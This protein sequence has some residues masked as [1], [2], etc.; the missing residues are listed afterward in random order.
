MQAYT[1]KTAEPGQRHSFL[2]KKKYTLKN[3]YSFSVNLL[4]NDI[5]EFANLLKD[6]R[7]K[8]QDWFETGDQ[9]SLYDLDEADDEYVPVSDDLSSVFIQLNLIDDYRVQQKQSLLDELLQKHLTRATF[10]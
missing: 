9:N 2:E 10:K 5:Q 7:H 6:F 1:Q 4:L 8:H 3:E